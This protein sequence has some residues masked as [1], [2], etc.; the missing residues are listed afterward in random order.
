LEQ[1]SSSVATFVEE[2]GNSAA[3]LID[4]GSTHVSNFIEDKGNQ[5]ATFI[6]EK[7][8]DVANWLE[9]KNSTAANLV[10]TA[11]NNTATF[12][13]DKSSNASNLVEEKGNGAA[14]FIDDKSSGASTFIEDNGNKASEFVDN[15]IRGF[16]NTGEVVERAGNL[17]NRL[18]KLGFD[19][20]EIGI[21]GSA[22]TGLSSKGDGFRWTET[23]G[24]LKPSDVDFFF[25]SRT[26]EDKVSRLGGNFV[27][28]RLKPE[29]LAQFF[30]EISDALQEFSE[31][32][33]VQIGRKSD[34]TLLQES[35]VGSLEPGTFTV[36]KQ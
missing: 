10:E 26:L 20:V 23:A 12:I 25:V 15:Y 36:F 1:K 18:I 30:P 16:R 32:T 11:G 2:K 3:D 22:V 6:D 13:D 9:D 19:D 34:A 14:T 35:L 33:T 31:Q 27:S 8:S 7:S 28:G 24:G 29:T 4:E 21:R 5:T 17:R